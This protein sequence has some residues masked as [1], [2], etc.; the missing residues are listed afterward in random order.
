MVDHCGIHSA[1]SSG[2]AACKTHDARHVA[3]LG[4]FVPIPSSSVCGTHTT[5]REAIALHTR[6]PPPINSAVIAS[7]PYTAAGGLSAHA[8][9]AQGPEDAH[10][11]TVRNFCVKTLA[12]LAYEHAEV[13][14]DTPPATKI[15]DPKHALVL[16]YPPEH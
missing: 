15:L 5:E 6:L 16:A 4:G 13:R 14:S 2:F 8:A 7:L 1:I 10:P 12:M 9:H 11:R 3:T